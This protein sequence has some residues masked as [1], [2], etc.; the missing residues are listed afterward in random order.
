MKFYNILFLLM[1]TGLFACS[2]LEEELNEDLSTEEAREFLNANADIDALLLG[3]Y[4]GIKG[5]FHTNGQ[6]QAMG[7]IASDVA[8]APTRGGDWDDGGKWRQFHNHTFDG[9]NEELINAWNGMLQVVFN[10]TNVLSFDVASPQQLAEAKFL[11]AFAMYLVADGFNQVPVREPGDNLLLPSTVLKG[12][13][14]I[15]FVISELESIIN[16]LPDGPET[17]ANK[18]AARVL[19]MKAHLNRGVYLD[20]GRATDPKF[21]AADLSKVIQYADEI[22]NSGNYGLSD[23]YFDN[24][25][26]NN[27]VVSKENIFTSPNGP[28]EN[29]GNLRFYWYSGL[30]YNQNPGGWNGFATLGDFYDSFEEGDQRRYTEYPGSNDNGI[31]NGFLIGQQFSGPAGTGD[32]LTDRNDNPLAYVKEVPLVVPPEILEVA[33]VRVMKYPIDYSNIDDPNNDGVYFRFSD[34]WLMKA[35]AEMRNGN[36]ATALDM[37]NTLRTARGASELASLDE[38]E[39]LAERGRE[40]YWENWRRTDLIRFGRFLDA[41]SDKPAGD[42][43][44]LLFPIP[45][46][47]L[48]VNPNLEQNPGY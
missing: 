11:R 25:A 20:Q 46:A 15:T 38:A 30:H 7:C 12:P 32:A 8:I 36:T 37:V 17:G 18:D 4:E 39:L 29:G 13:E 35:E 42:A 1:L 43:S 16:D 44:R 28:N 40:L 5:P 10:A 6:F 45:T 33:G 14:A 24:F 9:T 26:P 3:V 2:D 31:A 48:A 47:Q 23:N 41:W 19:L 27:D 21:D 34:V 22:I